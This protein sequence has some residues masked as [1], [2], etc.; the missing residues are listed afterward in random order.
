MAWIGFETLKKLHSD[1]KR[2]QKEK[3]YRKRYD[4]CPIG[5]TICTGCGTQYEYPVSGCRNCG[6]SFVE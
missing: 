5:M 4:Y 6:K 1:W 3:E 2:R